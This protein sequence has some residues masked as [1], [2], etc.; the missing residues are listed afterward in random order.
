MR[1]ITLAYHDIVAN[2]DYASS[3]FPSA[4]ASAGKLGLSSFA[5]HL[6]ALESR[7]V[8]VSLA[9]DHLPEQAK[10]VFLTFDDG[11][12][13][14]HE[15]IAGLLEEHGWRGHFFIPSDYIG[16]AGF[17]DAAQIRALRH[18]GHVIG[19]HSCSHPP[20]MSKLPWEQL[21]REWGESVE[22]LSGILGEP[23]RTGAVPGGYYSAAVASAASS[24]GIRVLFNSEP[25]TRET[26]V[27][28]CRVLGRYSIARR[29]SAATVAAIAAG[30]P[31]P[32]LRQLVYWYTMKIPKTLGGEYWLELRKRIL[33]RTNT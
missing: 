32:R 21:L 15:C 22:I 13:S 7:A 16:Q 9:E 8:T 24:A 26:V 10:P 5:Q 12:V 29:H 20:R 4:D 18:R 31:G 33:A 28:Q 17:V 25:T 3:G 19:S 11:G 27:G 14:A 1:A 2:W 30:A 23:V 6:A